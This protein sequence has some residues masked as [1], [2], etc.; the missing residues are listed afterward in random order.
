MYTVYPFFWPSSEKKVMC[1]RQILGTFFW[2]KRFVFS[3]ISLCVIQILF[4]LI[5]LSQTHI[6]NIFGL[7]TRTYKNSGESC[8]S[9]WLFT[10]LGITFGH[11]PAAH[12]AMKPL[13]RQVSNVRKHSEDLS[14]EAQGGDVDVLQIQ[15]INGNQL[16]FTMIAHSQTHPN[17]RAMSELVRVVSGSEWQMNGCSWLSQWA[18]HCICWYFFYERILV[19]ERLCHQR[20]Q[21]MWV[22]YGYLWANRWL[23]WFITP[24]PVGS[25]LDMWYVGHCGTMEL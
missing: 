23:S 17:H 16:C 25:M 1:K 7:T 19:G 15:E 14:R 24:I 4:V 8:S 9:I 5:L 10:R 3:K 13:H 22:S 2:D 21:H 18:D 11:F 20:R 6:K 12:A